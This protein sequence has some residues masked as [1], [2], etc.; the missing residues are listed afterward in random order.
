MSQDPSGPD[1]ATSTTGD[2]LGAKAAKDSRPKA[3]PQDIF[4]MALFCFLVAFVAYLG[5]NLVQALLTKVAV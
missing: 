3:T 2:P 5:W 1:Q 4:S